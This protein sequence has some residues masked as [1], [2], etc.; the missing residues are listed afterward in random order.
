MSSALWSAQS[1]EEWRFPIRVV[2]H[3]GLCDLAPCMPG[4]QFGGYPDTNYHPGINDLTDCRQG[5]KCV[6]GK[7]DCAPLGC[8]A[9]GNGCHD[10]VG[11]PAARVLHT[12]GNLTVVQDL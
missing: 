4:G 6:A 8:V 9:S 3:Q 12:I 1:T 2:P 7:G 5:R 11:A 10:P